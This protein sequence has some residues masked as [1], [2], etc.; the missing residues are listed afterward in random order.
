V[1]L[2]VSIAVFSLLFLLPGDPL[3]ALMEDVSMSPQRMEELRE[4]MGLNDPIYVQYFRYFRNAIRGDLGRSTRSSQPVASVLMAQVGSTLE[5]ALAAL[6][7]SIALGIPSGVLAAINRSRW[8]D[9]MVMVLSLLAL[10]MPNFW[11]G[12]LLIILFSYNLD[13]LPSVGAGSVNQLIMP[14]LV[15]GL[16][17]MG[18]LARLTRS[19]VLDTLG[20]DYIRT[21]RAKGLSRRVVLSNHALRNAFL[22][23]LTVIG[24]NVASLLSGAVVVETV[25]SRPGIGRIAVNAIN[26]RDFPVVQGTVLLAAIFYVLANLAVDLSYGLVDPRIRYD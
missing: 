3:L 4:A 18:M 12:F 26:N 11:L 23:I 1:L 9:S 16:G 2:L 24:I 21:A 14:A 19:A 7:I 17:G 22:P 25:F 13:W 15:L 10:S 20:Q 6:T 8:T 5:L